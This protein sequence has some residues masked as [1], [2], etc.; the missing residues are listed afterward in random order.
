LLKYLTNANVKIILLDYQNDNVECSD[1][2]S[3]GVKNY[4]SSNQFE[5]ST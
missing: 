1:M 2:M 4:D 3:N 5:R